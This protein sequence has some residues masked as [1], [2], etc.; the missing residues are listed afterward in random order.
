M[1]ATGRLSARPGET[2]G[3]P[4]VD[5]SVVVPV[6]ECA[7]V[8]A[9]MAEELTAALDEQG[10]T[11][12]VVFVDDGST[13]GSLA[14]LLALAEGDERICV[15]ELER[16]FGQH[17]ALT[18]GLA[19]AAGRHLVVMDAD[20]QFDP[21]EIPRLRAL[22]DAGADLVSGIR[23]PRRDPPLRRVASGLVNG[24]SRIVTGTELQ[25]YGCPFNALTRELA[26]RVVAHRP[27][28]RFL[29]PL[30]VRLADDVRECRVHHRS[31]PASRPRS[32]YSARRLMRLLGGF[33]LDH[34]DAALRG[35]LALAGGLAAVGA[36]AHAASSRFELAESTAGRVTTLG[37]GLL[38]IGLATGVAAAA[39]AWLQRWSAARSTGLPYAV[40]GVHRVGRRVG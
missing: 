27:P 12:E 26:L 18:A 32:G 3:R 29:K 37:A 13:D 30:A 24:L 33:W 39:A 7:A 1:S 23:L 38:L 4:D 8:L 25:D 19:T 9:Q 14:I 34:A 22:L 16:N 10:P 6:F 2:A 5:L 31:R 15:V 28:G 21:H 17:A 20:L 35:T 11:W 40:R 36:V